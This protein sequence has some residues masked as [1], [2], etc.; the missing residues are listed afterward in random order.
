MNP[1]EL[2]ETTMDPARRVL[3][4]VTIADA[5]AANHVFD[6]LMGNDVSGRKTFIQSHAHEAVVDY[7]A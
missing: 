5:A 6:M 7:N 4:R 2:W 3:K 1:D